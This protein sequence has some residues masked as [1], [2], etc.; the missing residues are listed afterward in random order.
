VVLDAVRVRHVAVEDEVA[1]EHL[2][3]LSLM[4]GKMA[5]GDLLGRW[6]AVSAGRCDGGAKSEAVKMPRGSSDTPGSRPS[7]CSATP[8]RS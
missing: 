4:P 6:D 1:D 3:V 8:A 2:A 7:R 5:N